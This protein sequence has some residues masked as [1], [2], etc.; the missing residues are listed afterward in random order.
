MKPLNA[1]D[2]NRKIQIRR[3]TEVSDGKGGYVTE[4]ETI[5]EPWAEVKGQGGSEATIDHVLQSI[6]V[7]RIRIRWRGDVQAADQIRIGA[8]ELNIRSAEDPN[9]DR[10]QLV[11]IADT[12]A[13]LKSS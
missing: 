8:L 5:A 1:G 12:G 6:S 10:E 13:A 11:I 3:S 4:W 9:G 2:L 7:Y